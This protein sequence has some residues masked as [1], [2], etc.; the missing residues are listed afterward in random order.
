MQVSRLLRLPLGRSGIR[1]LSAFFVEVEG[2]G[3]GA[4]L[5]NADLIGAGI[6]RGSKFEESNNERL[7]VKYEGD[8]VDGV[9]SCFIGLDSEM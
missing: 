6:F 3:A 2:A 9:A 5:F 8:C 4:R 7:F 1:I